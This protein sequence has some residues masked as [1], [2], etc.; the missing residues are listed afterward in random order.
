M[1]KK[2]KATRS[3]VTIELPDELSVP[4]AIQC[5]QLGLMRSEMAL[6]CLCLGS[7]IVRASF[8][9]PLE[10]RMWIEVMAADDEAAQRTLDALAAAV[11]EAVLASSE[12][13]N[14]QVPDAKLQ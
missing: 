3:K 10:A 8:E 14:D 1:K 13:R 12:V 4:F 11:R 5:S 6:F 7:H 9:G 2:K